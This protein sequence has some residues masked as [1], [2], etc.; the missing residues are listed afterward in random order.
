MWTTYSTTRALAR[1]TIEKIRLNGSATV[2]AAPKIK[3][4]HSEVL[5][6]SAEYNL[7]NMIRILGSLFESDPTPSSGSRLHNV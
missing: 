3:S 6:R 2:V 4:G 7:N 1:W 5:C